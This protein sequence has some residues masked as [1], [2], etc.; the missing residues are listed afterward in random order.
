[1]A[2]AKRKLGKKTNV[3]LTVQPAQPAF[4][5]PAEPQSIAETTPHAAF[6]E[7]IGQC[8]RCTVALED[9]APLCGEGAKLR[10]ACRRWDADH[11]T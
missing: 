10:R 8:N 7:H 5:E 3:T 6:S 4:P 1:M 9:R 2:K 11:A